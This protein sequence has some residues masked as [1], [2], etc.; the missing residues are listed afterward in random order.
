MN[1]YLPEIVGMVTCPGQRAVTRLAVDGEIGPDLGQQGG[2]GQLF[3][4]EPTSHAVAPLLPAQALYVP[5]QGIQSL[6]ST[7]TAVN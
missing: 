1:N 4:S 3:I 6:D 5:A 2:H 7:Y